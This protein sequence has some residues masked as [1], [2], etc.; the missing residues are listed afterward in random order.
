MKIV[1]VMPFW[2]LG[3][4]EI[5]CENL[6]YELKELGHNVVVISLYD[7]KTAITQRFEEAGIDIRY[8]SKK[9][10]FDLSMYKK[11]KEIF[12]HEHPD[13]IH[14]HIHTTQY[15]F[16]ITKKLKIKTI[17][18]IHSIALK[19]APRITRFFNKYYF[20][21][22]Y[23]IPVALSDIVKQSVI[24]VYKLAKDSVPVV[25]NGI[26][27]SKCKP[28]NGYHLDEKFKIVHVA[29]Y[30]EVKNHIGLIDAFEK[31]CSK[32]PCAEL[33]LIGDGQRRS[34]IEQLVRDKNLEECVIFHGFQSCVHDFLQQM[35]L[36]TLPSL[37]EG[38]PM[39][40][41]E[42]MGTGLPIV[43]TRV[44]GI[45]NLLTN[46]ESAILTAVDSDE[47]SLAFE[48]LYHSAELR[49]R[50]GKTALARSK[51]FSSKEMA[52]KYL[53]IYERDA[54]W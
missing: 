36:F 8:L 45:P 29:S 47:I 37:Y 16:P 5:M 52:R 24:D 42:A 13:V 49:E 34:I 35:D 20:K 53:E 32:Y 3:G 4:A 50:L 19:E 15:V 9:R 33:H 12:V 38:I 26:N 46:D 48:K 44:G 51:D 14:T 27:L 17:H 39:S 40:I 22:F 21:H 31:F 18:T 54:K 28:K 7:T 43:A 2:G 6:I 10:G 41:L 30:Q 11:L 25:F 23:A 1:E